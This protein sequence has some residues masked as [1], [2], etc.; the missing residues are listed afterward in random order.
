MVGR[1]PDK[2]APDALQI[3]A[4]DEAGRPSIAQLNVALVPR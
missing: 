4:L 2:L 3:F 1:P